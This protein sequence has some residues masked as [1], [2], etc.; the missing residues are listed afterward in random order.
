MEKPKQGQPQNAANKQESL[1]LREFLQWVK[2]RNLLRRRYTRDTVTA[3]ERRHGIHV[4]CYLFL[5]LFCMAFCM[6]HANFMKQGIAPAAVPYTSDMAVAPNPAIHM[7]DVICTVHV[8]IGAESPVEWQTPTTTVGEILHDMGFI[9][10]EEDFANVP[11]DT[12]CEDGMDIAVTLVTYE[13]R[14]EIVSVP[15]ET[16]YIDVQ[17]IPKGTTERV[18]H[19][20]EGVAHETQ[21]LRFENGV[22]VSTEVLSRTVDTPPVNEQLMRGIGGTVSGVDGTFHYSYYIDVT[23]TAYGPPEFTGLTYTGIQVHEG[24]IAVDP[25]VIPLHTKVYVKGKAGDFGVCYAE[26]IG[27]GIKNKHIDIFMNT[28]YEAMMQF[29]FRNMRVY[30]LDDDCPFH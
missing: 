6:T 25:T 2:R 4:V 30:V 28:T 8:K 14:E 5:L 15:F 20:I 1:T 24:V 12:V 16:E 19:G 22:H 21:R 26:D 23:A 9:P 3:N 13:E 29:G 18:S 27:G 11:Y 7:D 10:G 17:T